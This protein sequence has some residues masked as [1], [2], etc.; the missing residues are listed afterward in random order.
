MGMYKEC[1]KSRASV[2]SQ[3]TKACN[4]ICQLIAEGDEHTAVPEVVKHNFSEFSSVHDQVVSKEADKNVDH[5]KYFDVNYLMRFSVIMSMHSV[6]QSL[7]C[8]L[9]PVLPVKVTM[10]F[11]SY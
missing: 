3:V 4:R 2:K 1:K 8:M 6:K 5:D 7:S 9:L 10:M 11:T